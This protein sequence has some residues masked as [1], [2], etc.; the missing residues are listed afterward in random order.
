MTDIALLWDQALGGCDLGLQD[1]QLLTDD[2][3]DTAILISLF[4]DAR[5]RPDDAIPN[6]DDPRGWWGDA[7]AA[8]GDE[9]G[10]RLWLLSREKQTAQTLERARTY[11]RE[12]LS[13]LIAD[14]V[15]TSVEIT[16]EAQKTG[17]G[18][19]DRLA[20]GVEITR[21]TG[22]ARSRYDYIWDQTGAARAI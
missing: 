5:A 11:A 22:P 12:S 17:S 20:I 7:F 16:V 2:G 15:A 21:P 6:G 4:T 1:G 10:S 13:W 18:T 9:T 8:A 14:G 19:N 3:L